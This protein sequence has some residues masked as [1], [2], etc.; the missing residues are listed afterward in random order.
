MNPRVWV[1]WAKSVVDTCSVHHTNHGTT[2]AYLLQPSVYT[3]PFV[4]KKENVTKRRAARRKR[5]EESTAAA[6]HCNQMLGVQ[7]LLRLAADDSEGVKG[8]Y[9]STSKPTLAA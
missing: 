8:V 5:T 7:P 3:F 9:R 6:Y 1:K 4:V 2:L